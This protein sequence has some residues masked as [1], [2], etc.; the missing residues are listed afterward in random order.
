MKKSFTMTSVL[1]FRMQSLVLAL[2]LLVAGNSAAVVAQQTAPRTAQDVQA[3]VARQASL[4]T[5]F[6]VN[7]LKVLFK[8]RE[9]SWTVS[10][11]LFI[12]GGARNITEENAGLELFMLR[13]ATEASAGY[14]RERLR[15]ELASM[16][17]VLGASI[18]NDY[19]VLSLGSTKPHFQR[20]WQL[21]ADVALRPAF[22][23][24]DVALTQTRI[25]SALRDDTD[26]PDSHL[27]RLTERSAYAGH[28]Y[29]NNP[30][31]TV[32]SIS[33]LTIADLKAYHASVMQTS[34]LLLVVVGDLDLAQLRT[35]VTSAFGKLPRG[36][37]KDTP[38]AQ[39]AFDRSTV[40]VTPK[41]L[42]TNYVQGVYAAPPLTS[43]DIYPMRVAS[44]ILR[45]RVFEE[46]RARRNLSYA[47]SAFLMSQGANLGGIYVTAVD[48]NQAVR[49]MLNEVYRL[50]TEPVSADDI[51]GVVAQFLTSYYLEQE[52]NPAQ[53][54]EL[55]EYEL[56]GGGW[57]N[58][59]EVI[60]RVKEVTPA[61][62]QAA[63]QKYM[64]NMRFVVLGNPTSIDSK[65]FTGR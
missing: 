28:P 23:K 7:G 1:S 4:V 50:Q 34:R 17:T 48:A 55:A 33:R 13:A 43:D 6:E 10:A 5:E 15:S 65:V 38:V 39:L 25:V 36:D 51:E 22:A 45:D 3:V 19:S 59:V 2:V 27:Q 30:N 8:R 14:P 61:Q 31:G 46:V 60:E 9:G 40:E 12:R 42:F 32:G 56:I 52:T 62:V 63:A 20:S 26:N 21:F 11:G 18:N 44:T 49:V 64:R 37:Y 58:S 16:G 47:P 35:A 29:L 41:E 57:R 54:G 24:E 53:A